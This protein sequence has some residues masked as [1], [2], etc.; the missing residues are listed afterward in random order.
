MNISI[1]FL[2]S[3]F[4]ASSN[5]K[6]I[7]INILYEKQINKEIADDYAKVIKNYL[8]KYCRLF[9]VEIDTEIIGFSEYSTNYKYNSFTKLAGSDK[10]QERI[11]VMNNIF[12]SQYTIILISYT[13]NAELSSY[14]EKY[15]CG[16][17]YNVN[18]NSKNNYHKDLLSIILEK[19]YFVFTDI[20]EITIPDNL[21]E[22]DVAEIGKHIFSAN[23]ILKMEKCQKKIFSDR[24]LKEIEKQMAFFK[25]TETK[26]NRILLN[27][28]VTKYYIDGNEIKN[29]NKSIGVNNL[30][31]HVNLKE[32]I[33][34][35]AKPKDKKTSITKAN[36]D[37]QLKDNKEKK[38]NKTKEQK[39]TTKEEK[40]DK[41]KNTEKQNKDEQENKKDEQKNKKDEKG[42]ETILK[43]T[44]DLIRMLTT[45]N[46]EN[47]QIK[48]NNEK[49]DI[50][51]DSWPV[52]N[53]M[54]QKNF[55]ENGNEK[56]LSFGII[57]NPLR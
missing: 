16:G 38:E 19:V 11:K 23:I 50:F 40:P 1:I 3:M 47:P 27:N 18:L 52:K 24:M 34:P 39:D 49:K 15:P 43:S 28:D 9:N 6:N 13:N 51:H 46:N 21:T 26:N 55:N 30:Q 17:V 22:Y 2:C 10:I 29:Q 48:K 20:F 5:L 45:Q 4:L 33:E 56:Q 25:K 32:N 57:P 36:E 54:T 35:L 44:I 8:N 12:P 42:L 14:D 31:P 7:K 41:N 37:K 53:Y